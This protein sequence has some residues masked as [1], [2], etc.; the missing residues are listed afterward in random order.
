M[1]NKLSFFFLWIITYDTFWW[2]IRKKC[3]TDDKKL[4]D[5]IKL[6]SNWE[7]FLLKYFWTLY[8]SVVLKKNIIEYKLFYWYYLE[9]GFLKIS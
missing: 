7:L 8:N 3:K 9:Y 4:S 6:M 1:K 2:K 5:R